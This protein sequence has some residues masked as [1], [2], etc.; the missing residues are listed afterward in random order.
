VSL[1]EAA[2]QLGTD[3]ATLYRCRHGRMTTD[4]ADRFA[5]GID[6]HPSRVWGEL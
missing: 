5:I 4:M 2:R 6:R 1:L 3:P